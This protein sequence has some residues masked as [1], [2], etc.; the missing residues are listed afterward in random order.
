MLL[1]HTMH[2]PIKQLSYME[3]ILPSSATC[4]EFLRQGEGNRK[5]NQTQE[6]SRSLRGHPASSAS[7]GPPWGLYLKS[8]PSL[9]SRCLSQPTCLLTWGRTPFLPSSLGSWLQHYH[10]RRCSHNSAMWHGSHSIRCTSCLNGHRWPKSP[11]RLSEQAGLGFT[12]WWAE[13]SK[14]HMWSDS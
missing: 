3:G 7:L 13:Q 4:H 9:T 2:T 11:S 12:C 10:L 1:V 8:Q 6:R 14:T 5:R